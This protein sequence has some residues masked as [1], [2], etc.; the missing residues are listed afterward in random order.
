MK[1]FSKLFSRSQDLN[2]IQDNVYRLSVDLNALPL[3][4]SKL[5]TVS[6]LADTETIVYLSPVRGYII[7][8]KSTYA[9]V[10]TVS[11]DPLKIKANA[12]CEFMLA[13]LI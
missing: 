2:I 6:L 8:S 10:L 4:N 13:L 9:D 12:N 5:L 3:V 7:V 11:L 1:L